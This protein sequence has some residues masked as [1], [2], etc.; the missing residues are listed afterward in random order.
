MAGA[1]RSVDRRM[2]VAQGHPAVQGRGEAGVVG[3]H[4]PGGAGAIAFE[5]VLVGLA[6]HV[7]EGGE[8]QV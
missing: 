4:H 7:A 2:G 1:A 6:G 5:A 8:P 3:Q